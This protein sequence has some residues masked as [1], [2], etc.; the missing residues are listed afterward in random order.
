MVTI[1]TEVSDETGIASVTL[2]W[3]VDGT[4]QADLTMLAIILRR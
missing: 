1:R 3:W 2:K 4:P